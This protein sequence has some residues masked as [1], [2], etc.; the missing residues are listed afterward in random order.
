MSGWWQGLSPNEQT[1]WLLALAALLGAGVAALI[2]WVRISRVRADLEG[3]LAAAEAQAEAARQIADER[4][5]V[6]AD[7]R[8]QLEASFSHLSGQALKTNS[9]AFLRIAGERFKVQ[10]KEAQSQFGQQQRAFAELVKPIGQT[11]K[12]TETQI[13]EIEKERR[14]AFGALE[15]H[16]QLMNQEQ[17]ALQAETRNLVQALRRPEVRGRWGEMT[18]RRLVELAGMVERCDF[19]EQVV[20]QGEDGGLRPDMVVHLPDDRDIVVDV[21]TP[22]DAYL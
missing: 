19:S 17:Q 8:A 12:N 14:N 16:L 18:L 2:A 21:K 15:K 20:V 7:S 9:E 11:L 3:Q 22:L 4:A 13:R 6:F 1:A 5:R 10:Q